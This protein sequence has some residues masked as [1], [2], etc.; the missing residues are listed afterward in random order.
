MSSGEATE[1]K[2]STPRNTAAEIAL[3]R[4]VQVVARPT[5]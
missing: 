2:K 3:N 4:M 1:M 5:P